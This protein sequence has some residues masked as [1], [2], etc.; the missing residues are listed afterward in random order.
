MYMMLTTRWKMMK[1][2]VS[3]EKAF[4]N[5]IADCKLERK[6]VTKNELEYIAK[7]FSEQNNSYLKNTNIEINIEDILLRCKST[8][9]DG[10]KYI[11][12]PR[13]EEKSNPAKIIP[14]E[15]MALMELFKANGSYNDEVIVML[16]GQKVKLEFNNHNGVNKTETIEISFEDIR[17]KNDEQY[18]FVN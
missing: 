8:M 12:T 7:K 3:K 16:D 11:L 14:L 9:A 15:E 18:E 13:E 2:S 5:R 6:V 10:D 17:D 1:N 4:R